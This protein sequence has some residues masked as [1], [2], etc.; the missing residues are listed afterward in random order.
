MGLNECIIRQNEY[1]DAYFV[2]E[3]GSF[4]IIHQ[5]SMDN[6]ASKI[7]GEMLPG[8]AFG[9]GSLL[10]SIPRAAT[11]RATKMCVVWALDASKFL[12]IRQKISQQI[13]DKTAKIVKY[14][15]KISLF[16]KYH[17]QDLVAVGQAVIERKYAKN[18][19]IIQQGGEAT[20]FFFDSRRRGHCRDQK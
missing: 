18:S 11:L 8:K 17:H 9:E 6:A 10:Y 12:E 15:K 16:K 14:L 3:S 4:D 1:G 20:E 5:E 13:N 19:R 2:I 7:V